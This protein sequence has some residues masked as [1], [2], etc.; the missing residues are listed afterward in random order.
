MFLPTGGLAVSL[1]RDDSPGENRSA[2]RPPDLF[3]QVSE[4]E[5][6]HGTLEA[7]MEIRHLAFMTCEDAAFR[8]PAKM[9]NPGHVAQIAA[10]PVQSFRDQDIHP[11]FRNFTEEIDQTG[12]LHRRSGNGRVLAN[13]YDDRPGELPLDKVP[14]QQHLVGN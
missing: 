11:S 8:I 6:I 7:D 2:V 10:D 3:L 9:M 12:A 13:F 5:R 1:A 14:A 4:K